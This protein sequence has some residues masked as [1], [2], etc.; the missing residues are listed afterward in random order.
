MHLFEPMHLA[1]LGVI[2]MLF[3]G[4][5]KIPELM[6]GIGKGMGELQKG[7]ADGKAALST[8]MHDIHHET[9]P[10]PVAT[11]APEPEPMAEPV[12]EPVVLPAPNTV[13]KATRVRKSRTAKSA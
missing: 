4:P 8:A 12:H 13:P 10:E 11:V 7:I 2:V 1:I 9:T 5:K 6:R 3:F